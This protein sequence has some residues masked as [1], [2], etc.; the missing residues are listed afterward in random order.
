MTPARNF[1][2]MIVSH[3]D[4]LAPELVLPNIEKWS[5]NI[6]HFRWPGYN[7]NY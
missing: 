5:V 3:A 4:S 7:R 2:I 6:E 1:F